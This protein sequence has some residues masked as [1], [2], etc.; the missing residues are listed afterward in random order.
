[1]LKGAKITPIT[2]SRVQ[3]TPTKAASEKTKIK[4][5]KLQKITYSDLKILSLSLIDD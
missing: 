5:L 1:M 4:F 3:F 2:D